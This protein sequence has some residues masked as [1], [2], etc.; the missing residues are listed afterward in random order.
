MSFYESSMNSPS[1]SKKVQ[2]AYKD[3]LNSFL[4]FF[5]HLLQMMQ[6]CFEH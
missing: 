2:K 1:N 4:L 3:T 6:S 5:S